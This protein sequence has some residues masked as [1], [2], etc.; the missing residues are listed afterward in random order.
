MPGAGRLT[1][2]AA[3][4]ISGAVLA[5]AA[6]AAL[7]ISGP[8]RAGTNAG[9]ALINAIGHPRL[10]WQAGGKGS[11]ITLERCDPAVQGQ[12]WSLTGDGV[13]MNGNG[14]CLE[15]RTGEPFGVPLNIDFAGQCAGGAQGPGNGQGQVWRYRA[16]QLA[17]AGTCAGAG[18]P[19]APGTEIVRRACPGA[20]WSIGYSAVTVTAEN[21]SGPA[22]GTFT[23]SATAA[24]AA[25]AQAAYGV[26]VTFSLPPGLAVSGLR[27]DRVTGSGW[28]CDVRTLTCT[29][30]LPSG[31]AAKVTGT[32]PLP[33]AARRGDTFT[34]WARASVHGTSQRPGTGHSA[35]SLALAVRAPAPPAP[36]AAGAAGTGSPLPLVAAVAG[37]VL[38]AGGLLLLITRRT[39]R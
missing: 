37:A 33:A 31:A 24:N 35:A 22:G 4:L 10:C 27:V 7:S 23:A 29:G 15:A 21:G 5:V 39:P 38:L 18:G 30:T 14:Y 28:H 2:V 6:P 26:A 19:V 13:V 25:S 8:A 1:V 11:A 17:S 36:G 12:Q 20:R 16:G 34:V 3:L 32:G 9:P